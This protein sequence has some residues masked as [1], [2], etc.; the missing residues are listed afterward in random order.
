LKP[1]AST[2]K[3]LDLNKATVEELEAELPGVGP[4][5]AKKIVA[6]RPYASVDDLAKAGVPARVI[7]GIRQHVSISGAMVEKSGAVTST[8]TTAKIAESKVE[9]ARETAR[10]KVNLNAAG[11]AALEELPGIGPATAKAIIEGRPWQSVDELEKIRGLGKNRIVALRDLVTFG[12]QPI[13]KEGTAATA[14]PRIAT[15]KEPP[16]RTAATKAATDSTKAMP[17]LQPGQ[18]ININTASLEELDALPGIGP[19]K[20]QAIVAGRP[21]KSIEDIKNVKGIKDGQFVKIQDM[22]TVK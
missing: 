6:G 21:F 1:K 20:A 4:S 5:T 2:T 12:D 7:E 11:S 3:V 9:P 10:G 18:K 8:T 19:V 15:A 17:K 16:P 13:P 22:I 14:S